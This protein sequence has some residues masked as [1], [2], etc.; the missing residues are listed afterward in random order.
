MKRIVKLSIIAMF[1][2]T[3]FPV[4]TFAENKTI[5][6]ISLLEAPVTYEI[7]SEEVKVIGTLTPKSVN[8]YDVSN[9]YVSKDDESFV[10]Y[11]VL[12]HPLEGYCF[13][14]TL[15]FTGIKGYESTKITNENKSNYTNFSVDPQE[16]DFV[17]SWRLYQ[18]QSLPNSATSID[19]S[20]TTKTKALEISKTIENPVEESV[21]IYKESSDNYSVL[22]YSEESGWTGSTIDIKD[23]F[24]N[25]ERSNYYVIGSYSTDVNACIIDSLDN[26]YKVS[27]LDSAVKFVK[28]GETIKLLNDI[29]ITTKKIFELDNV[30]IDLNEYKVTAKTNTFILKGLFTL[31]NGSVI[32]EEEGDDKIL[33]I[34][35]SPKVN[36]DY[37]TIKNVTFDRGI[38]LYG[39]EVVLEDVTIDLSNASD[40]QQTL[41]YL[42]STTIVHQKSGYYKKKASETIG[43][44]SL[45]GKL[46]I[47]GGYYSNSV[48]QFLEEG[49]Q[50]ISSDD[51]DYLYK[52]VKQVVEEDTSTKKVV[53]INKVETTKDEITDDETKISSDV[54]DIIEEE[55]KKIETSCIATAL[56]VDKTNELKDSF[57]ESGTK[58]LTIETYINVKAISS[59]VTEAQNVTLKTLTFS[60]TPFANVYESGTGKQV[61]S[62]LPI[63]NSDLDGSKI[64]IVLPTGGIKPEEIVHASEDTN[65]SKQYFYDESNPK[66]GYDTF[67]YDE[68]NQTVTL[69]ISHF[70]TLEINATLTNPDPNLNEKKDDNKGSVNLT[71]DPEYIVVNTSTK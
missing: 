8:K 70:S 71:I 25:T 39:S 14:E 13:G 24:R 6:A 2:I 44:A 17:V 50:L 49:C 69:Y 51:K 7:E 29:S 52:V 5:K 37:P 34:S 54:K 1:L 38:K 55:M 41:I 19:P 56:K 42:N 21:I 64:K 30:T 48:V 35:N 67:S 53:G 57:S 33:S 20:N 11:E 60:A 9:I 32:A 12:V 36:D 22:K 43:K 28:T 18:L 45:I 65:Y 23:T 16:G 10:T 63:S 27:S 31:E 68:T 47:S 15:S 40:D 4:K 3:F 61:Q 66:E 58:E 46:K 62:D 59:T 26:E